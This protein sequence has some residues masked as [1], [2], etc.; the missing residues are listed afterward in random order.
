MFPCWLVLVLLLVL[1]PSSQARVHLGI[2]GGINNTSIKGDSPNK[3]SLASLPGP[4][5]GVVCEFDIAE[6]VRLSIQ[7][8]FVQKGSKLQFEVED[9]EELVD[10]LRVNLDYVSIPV[11]A[12]IM[13]NNRRT[14]VTGGLDLG[15]LIKATLTE[16][17][18]GDGADIGDLFRTTDL[19]AT[20]GFGVNFPVGKPTINA[21]IRY[22]QSILNI[23]ESE[24][25]NLGLPVRFRSSGFQLL[26]GALI[27][28]GGE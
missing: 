22:T 11:L 4:M 20:L 15:F 1:P 6:D 27:P 12:K 9:Q 10:S 21:E 24:Q 16:P 19:S 7:P 13:A 23:A 28:L 8:M 18:Q 3:V 14:Y 2:T 25:N 5:L 17:G 26:V